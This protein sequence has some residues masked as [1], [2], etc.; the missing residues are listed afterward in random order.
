MAATATFTTPNGSQAPSAHSLL[1]KAASPCAT[2][3]YN[4]LAVTSAVCETPSLFCTVT[5]QDRTAITLSYHIRFLFASRAGWRIL[6]LIYWRFR[7]LVILAAVTPPIYLGTSSFTASGWTG[8]FY[9]RRLR[10]AEQLN[11]YAQHFRTVEVDSTFYACPAEQTVRQWADRTPQ[12]F[13]FSLKIPQAITHEKALVG[14]EPELAEFLRTVS[15]LGH[16]L[17]PLVFQFPFFPRTVFEDRHQF[18][19]RLVPFLKS[20]PAGYK[21]AIEIRNRNWLDAEFVGLLRD[22]GVALV[23]QDASRM[24]NPGDLKFDPVTTEWTYIRWLG[25]R[26]A[27]EEQTTTWDKTIVDRTA[28][29]T[30]WV[31]FCY[32]LLRR[33]VVTYAYANNHYAGHAPATIEKFKGIWNARGFPPLD[34]QSPGERQATLF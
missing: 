27:I 19:D 16:K 30:R 32:K 4:E 3:S 13:T 28:E 26:K 18:L 6:T 25:D 17:G 9:P 8:S 15:L 1:R 7:F 23:L 31:D 10:P 14:C 12:G 21:W 34:S 11:F 24:P 2:A 22:Q 20:L 29:L 5:R 33:G